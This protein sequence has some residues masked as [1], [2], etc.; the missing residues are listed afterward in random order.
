[1]EEIPV[2]SKLVPISSVF[3]DYDGTGYILIPPDNF[4]KTEEDFKAFREKL[5]NAV[6]DMGL[7]KRGSE[8][9]QDNKII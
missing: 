2:G 3:E 9:T 1:M 8:A 6:I 4:L 5:I 7:R